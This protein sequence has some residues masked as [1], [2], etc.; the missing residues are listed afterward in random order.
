M[1]IQELI[2]A[3]V[4]DVLKNLDL[5]AIGVELEHPADISHGDYASTIALKV[6][7]QAC[8]HP[9]ELAQRIVDEVK[10]NIPSWL[11]RVEVAGPGFINFTLSSS[12][13]ASAIG[14]IDEQFGRN[15]KLAGKKAI[16]E[17]TD[18]NPFK[19][20]HIGH[21][22]SNTVGESLSRVIE[23]SGAE[24]MRACYQGDVGMH[25]AKAIWGFRRLGEDTIPRDTDVSTQVRYLGKAYATGATAYEEGGEPEAQMKA[26]NAA[27]YNRTD[28]EINAL[29]DWGRDV[30]LRYFETQYKALGT[31]HDP[32]HNK[33]FNFYFFES[34]VGVLGRQLVE[35]FLA[36]GVFEKSDNAVVFPGEKYGL[37]TRVF[38]N[39]QGLPTYEAKELGLA[40][41]KYDTY[42]YDI[43]VVV[44]GNEIREYFK[45]LMKALSLINPT[46]QEK[47]VHVPHGMLRLTT[48]KM[49]S[50]TGKVVT[51]ES[52]ITSIREKVGQHEGRASDE[53][54][55]NDIAV[56][57]IK[58]AVLKQAAGKDIIFDAEQSV[59]FE[60]DSGPYLQYAYVRCQSILRKAAE[61]N[62]A[63]FTQLPEGWT[64]LELE[65]ML[66][67]FPELVEQA[68]AEYSS[69]GI[70]NYL[71]ALARTF[72]S[73]YGNT[74]IVD[75]KNPHT[76]YRLALVQATG[77]VIKNGLW[78]LGIKTPE[79]M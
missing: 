34:N 46:L 36:K 16:V 39:S 40:H 32:E 44:T 35:E 41:V 77:Q 52:L 70:A 64:T 67:Q 9:R 51:A 58:Y 1:N 12:F 65:R 28:V 47:T 53:A 37:H 31:F 73:W 69:H 61:Q 42:P 14:E 75:D 60:G 48:G 45:V 54:T 43:S 33:A 27:I 24:T 7:K 55:L 38:L 59:S 72:S 21:L 8:T 13:F 23:W 20:L 30:S 10:K 15:Q 29:Y 63:P 22:M 57:A 2:S 19:E 17:Y 26:L 25:V 18:P 4:Q 49:S 62:L 50:R 11:E 3:A 74:K 71:I 56:A 6:A 76:P 68:L 5:P 79:K 78:L 66:Y